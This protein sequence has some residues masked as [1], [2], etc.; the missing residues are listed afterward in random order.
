MTIGSVNG[1]LDFEYDSVIRKQPIQDGYFNQQ[2]ASLKV[3]VENTKPS[4]DIQESDS[5]RKEISPSKEYEFN[6]KRV[7][8]DGT[9]NRK[10]IDMINNMQGAKKDEILDRYKFFVN[11]NITNTE[12]GTVRRVIR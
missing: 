8:E 9:G 6:L 7:R 2:K 11:S 10:D 4:I 3:E 5:K 12:D 1:M